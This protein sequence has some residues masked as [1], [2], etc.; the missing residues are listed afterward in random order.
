M[1]VHNAPWRSASRSVPAMA[2]LFVIISLVSIDGFF[3]FFSIF[4]PVYASHWRGQAVVIKIWLHI[5]VHL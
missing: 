4:F 2:E 1:H 3:S 5:K